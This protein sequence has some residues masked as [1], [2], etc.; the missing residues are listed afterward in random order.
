MHSGSIPHAIHSFNLDPTGSA[1]IGALF[2]GS[3]L[4]KHPPV[5]NNIC[6]P[7]KEASMKC[8]FAALVLLL[9]TAVAYSQALPL[10]KGDH[11]CLLGNALADRMQHHG[12]L[13]TLL[14][15]RFPEHNLVFRDLGF[16]GDELTVRLRSS[17]FG[18][19]DEW[20]TS[21]K[22]DVI[23][24]FFGYNESFAGPAGLDKFKQD[25]DQFI[26]HTLAQKYNSQSPPR[27]VL[28]SPIAHED[29]HNRNYP[30][31]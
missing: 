11:I 22:A 14:Q 12:W 28:F 9:S 2:V 20:L 24:V 3:L 18:S 23:F 30:D 25:L 19:P 21:S 15:S 31:W 26:K 29:L 13:E 10:H 7:Q 16:S 17:G 27:L 6:T 4:N 8:T 5:P 1:L